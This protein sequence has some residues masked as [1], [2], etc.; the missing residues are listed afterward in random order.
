MSFEQNRKD[1]EKNIKLGVGISILLHILIIIPLLFIKEEKLPEF[2]EGFSY[3][4]AADLDLTKI[5]VHNY[6]ILRPGGGGGGGGGEDPNGKGSIKEM[7][8]GIPVPSADPMNVEFGL[9]NTP[10]P[11]SITDN[12]N[13]KSGLG[14]GSGTGSGRGSGSGTGVGSGK[15]SGIGSGTGDGTMAVSFTPR[16]ILEVIPEQRSNFKGAVKL[17]VRI[18][19]EGL[20][21]DHKVLQN[22]TNSS[23]C[24]AEVLKAAYKSKWQSVKI[25][26]KLIEYWT[27]KTYRFE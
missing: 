18:G 14:Y 8:S 25:E 15:G 5:E 13:L 4:T 21:K 11:D 26:G 10:K 22:S 2:K 12:Q 6:E 20:V 9:I 19:K 24:L 3:S 16:Q 27:E 1:Y 23:E 7:K 17:S